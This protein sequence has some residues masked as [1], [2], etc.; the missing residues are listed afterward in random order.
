M[1]LKFLKKLKSSSPTKEDIHL[2]TLLA[3]N[4]L[5]NNRKKYSKFNS[6]NEAEE[7]FFSQNGEDGII[8]FLLECMKINSPKFL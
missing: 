2:K 1:F 4:I 8:D 5:I 7:K 6:I 3:K